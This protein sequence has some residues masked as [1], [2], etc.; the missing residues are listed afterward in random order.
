VR[1]SR[2]LLARRGNPYA[3]QLQ[4]STARVTVR[5]RRLFVFKTLSTATVIGYDS[6][7][8]LQTL[9]QRHRSDLALVIGNGINRYGRLLSRTRGMIC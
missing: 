9:L 4:G 1:A 2:V 8:K 6:L 3:L 5:A 7:M